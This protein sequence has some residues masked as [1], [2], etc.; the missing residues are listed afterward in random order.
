MT[1]TALSWKPEA[2]IGI[3]NPKSLGFTCMAT[4]AQPEIRCSQPLSQEKKDAILRALSGLLATATPVETMRLDNATL[5]SVADDAF[6]RFHKSD[7]RKE[8][9]IV[10]WQGALDRAREAL[11][12]AQKSYAGIRHQELSGISNDTCSGQDGDTSSVGGSDTDPP[13]GSDSDS[14]DDDADGNDDN[15]TAPDAKSADPTATGG[16]IGCAV[17]NVTSDEEVESLRQ[18]LERYRIENQTLLLQLE[19]AT[20]IGGGG[21]GPHT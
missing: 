15:G 10:Q 7:A 2:V 9:A 21:E 1:T 20:R 17:D 3:F 16:D 19:A 18:Q 14:S 5:R 12:A 6:C 4:K 13:S 11:A 8:N